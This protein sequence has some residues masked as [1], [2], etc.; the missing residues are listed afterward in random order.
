MSSPARPS[1]HNPD[2][3]SSSGLQAANAKVTRWREKHKRI[4]DMRRELPVIATPVAAGAR[5]KRIV[6]FEGIKSAG[7]DIRPGRTLPAL[8]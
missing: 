3:A 4:T 7:A 1:F 5:W 6:R 8:A 2:A